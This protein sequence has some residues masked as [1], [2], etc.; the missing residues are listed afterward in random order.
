MKKLIFLPIV[1]IFLL[2]FINCDKKSVD[3]GHP[4]VLSDL[5]APDSIQRNSPDIHYIFVT[6][7]DPDGLENIDRVFFRVTKPD[8]SHKPDS[9]PLR[10][11][12]QYGDSIANDSR[13]SVGLST[14]H[15]T[16][17]Q[18]GDY[19]FKFYAIDKQGNAS[20]NPQVTVTEY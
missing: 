8:G 15:D 4:P 7:Y 14:Y 6:V 5:S 13:F 11:D 12:G 19:I 2:S 17:S 18:L 16:T 1:F 9:I 10:D 3:P 20:N